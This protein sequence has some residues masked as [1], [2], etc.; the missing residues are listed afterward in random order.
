MN[1]LH[2]S[3]TRSS[4]TRVVPCG[5]AW[6]EDRLRTQGALHALHVMPR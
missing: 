5:P 1:Q 6:D 4:K 2:L 3:T